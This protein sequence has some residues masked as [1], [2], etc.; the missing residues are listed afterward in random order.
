M[1]KLSGVR[2]QLNT[3]VNRVLQKEKGVVVKKSGIPVVE[4]ASTEDQERLKRERA[5]R[6]SVI[7]EMRQAF[8]DVPADEI[9]RETDRVTDELRSENGGEQRNS[10][11]G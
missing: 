5:N 11:S 9:E 10:S 3:V 4:I 8:A 6:F 7:D 1:M 2:S